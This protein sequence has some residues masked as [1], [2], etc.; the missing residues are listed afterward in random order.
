MQAIIYKYEAPNGK[1]YIG[2]TTSESKRLNR[3]KNSTLENCYAGIKMQRAIE[4]YGKENFKYEILENLE[5]VSQE[6][7]DKLESYYIGVFDSFHN[8]YNNTLG[9]GGSSGYKMNEEQL[10][11]H[12][13]RMK[14]NNPFKGKKHSNESKEM[15][16]KDKRF[17]I[18]QIDTTTN[19]IIGEFE[20]ITEAAIILG[21]PRGKAE[22]A[23]VCKGYVS[24]TGRH[25]ITA[26]G[27]KWRYKEGSTTSL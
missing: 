11:K 21:K 14:T 27:F 15:I 25:Y 13:K 4:K 5:D 22:I 2:Q 23:K 7:L 19:E 6:E 20:S 18:Y 9:G 16:G 24:P 8:G 26:L 10:K 12:I 1:C 17:P 3:F